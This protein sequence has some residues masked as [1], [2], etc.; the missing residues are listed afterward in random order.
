M[1]V[2]IEL[3]TIYGIVL[4]ELEKENNSISETV[5]EYI[6]K[7]IEIGKYR[8]DRRNADLRNADLNENT[9]FLLCQCPDE[10]S[11]IAWKK[12]RQNI[13]KLEICKDALRSSATTLKCRCSKAK[14]LEI[15][16][17]DGTKSDFKKVESNYDASFIYKVGK[18]VSVDSFDTD[19]LNECSTGIHFFIS[20]EMAVKYN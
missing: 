19:R 1:K 4:F 18:I 11:F 9:A 12:C 16:N 17:F 2:K 13:V 3:K 15:Q 20:R 5:K 8:A 14:V 6:K 7:E 10:G